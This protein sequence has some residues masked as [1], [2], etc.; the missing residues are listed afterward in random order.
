VLTEEERAALEEKIR[1]KLAEKEKLRHIRLRTEIKGR[2]KGSSI[3]TNASSVQRVPSDANSTPVSITS[4]SVAP[5]SSPVSVNPL[6]EEIKML[7][8]ENVELRERLN[9]LDAGGELTKKVEDAIAELK[10][11]MAEKN[12]L[13]PVLKLLSEI[14][15]EAKGE[16]L[17]ASQNNSMVVAECEALRSEMRLLQ[18]KLEYYERDRQVLLE[19]IETLNT[20]LKNLTEF[21]NKVQKQSVEQPPPIPSE[22]KKKWWQFWKRKRE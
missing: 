6:K 10:E 5:A 8:R 17:P 15:E 3:W 20:S 19:Q 2:D 12:D 21:L 18:E 11:K 22:Q 4:E 9:Q 14:K 16:H 13:S 1:N 7:R